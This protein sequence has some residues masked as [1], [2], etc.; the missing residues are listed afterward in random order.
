M[1]APYY[2]AR[3]FRR[4][5]GF[6]RPTERGIVSN[7]VLANLH[8]AGQAIRKANEP[9]R[10]EAFMFGAVSAAASGIVLAMLEAFV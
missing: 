7:M 9:I 4:N 10:R 5:V 3:E 6:S 8:L 1:E 2:E